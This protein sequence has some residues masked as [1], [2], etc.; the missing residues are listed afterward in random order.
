MNTFAKSILNYFA[1]Y[2]ETRFRFQSKSLYKWTN[3]Q[4]TS[5]FPVFPEFQKKL[6]DTIKAKSLIDLT[7]RKGE[8]T[9]VLDLED[10]KRRLQR[11]LKDK[12]NLSYLD[13]L[14]EELRKENGIVST[15]GNT[16]ESKA[17][18]E[19]ILH[20]A[21]RKFNLNYRTVVRDVLLELQEEKKKELVHF[22]KDSAIPHTS[23]NPSLVEQSIYDA[24]QEQASRARDKGDF[25]SKL[26]GIIKAGTW[27]LEMYD[28]Y[29][30]IRK[31]SAM[32]NQTMGTAYIF[33]HQIFSPKDENLEQ[34]P[35]FLVEITIEE[36]PELVRI[37]SERGVVLINTPAINSFNFDTVLTIPRAARL[38]E[39]PDYL[40]GVE[41]FLQNSY[42]FFNTFLL[43]QAFAPLVATDK[44]KICFRVGFQIVLKEDRKLLDY[45]ELITRIDAGQGGKFIDFVKN[46]VSGN[47]Y[48]TTDEVDREYKK[49]YPPKT[50]ASFLSTIPLTLNR[51]QKRILTALENPKNKIIVIDGPPGT[52]KS[53]TIA[54]MTYW[55]NQN[56]K[57]VVITSHK[58]AAIDVLDRMMTDYF[59]KLHPM[60][61]PSIMRISRETAEG[62]NNFQN[63]LASPVISAAT[64]RA[65][66]FNKNAVE[67]DIE[68]WGKKVA[69][70]TEEYWVNA[71]AYI[72]R[73]KDLLRLEQI[74]HS[75]IQ[76]GMLTEE[77]RPEKIADTGFDIEIIKDIVAHLSNDSDELTLEKLVCLA[78]KK[79]SLDQLIQACNIVN[80]LPITIVEITRLKQVSIEAIDSFENVLHDFKH[81][82]KS[83]SLLFGSDFKLKLYARLTNSKGCKELPEKAKKLKSLEYGDLLNNIAII[84]AKNKDSLVLG[85]LIQG[86]SK[87]KKIEKEREHIDCLVQLRVALE[88]K[89]T[90]IKD[91]YS[92]LKSV[93]GL[94]HKTNSNALNNLIIFADKFESLLAGAKLRSNNLQDL[95]LL[96]DDS[97][98][99]KELLGYITL[100]VALSQ[101]EN[102][103]LPDRQL[104]ESYYESLHKQ[105]ENNN[106]ERFKNLNK[107]SGDIS[108]IET[109]FKT[110][111]RLKKEEAEVLLSNIS[112][113]LSEPDLISQYFPMEENLIDILVIDEAS[114]VS[115][116]ESIS[117][118]LR[119]KQVVVLG[120]E[121]QYGAVGAVNV[122]KEYAAQYFKE[123]LDSYE[124]DYHVAIDEIEKKAL[125]DEVSKEIEEDDQESELFFKP[126]E[127]TKEWLKTFNIRT[128][129]L[130]FAKA[131]RNFSTSLDTHFR[132]FSEII[133]YS[134]EFFYKPS[135]IPL[136]VNRI[137]T[138]PIKDVLRFIKVETKG[139]AGNNINLDEIEVIKGDLSSLITN[140]FKGTVGIITSFRE[141]KYQME[142][143]LRK[144][145]PNFHILE[146]DHKL[147]IWFVGDVQGEER[148][149]VYYS[150]VE[151]K[152]IGN[153][154]LKTIYP[155]PDGTADNIRKLKMQ[156]LNVGFSRAKDT[157]V[158]V[159][160]MPI[161]E[162]S[163]TRLGDALKY[164]QFLF[165]SA[166][167][168]Y[169]V[170][171]KIFGSEA[172]RELY[173]MVINTDFYRKNRDKIKLIAQFPIGKYI[174]ETFHRYIP[175]YR[176]DFLLTISERGKE[177]SLIL[178]YDGI[179]YHT[180]NPDMVTSHNFSQEYLDYDI[181]RQLELENYGYRF[182]RV[183]KFTLLPKEKGQTKID[184]L[185]GLLE[186]KFKN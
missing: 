67:K 88:D 90:E 160:S 60:A 136:I 39:A 92:L 17:L 35:L 124:K 13:S 66:E 165:Q 158:F 41:K 133:D 8:Y 5:D 117:L 178:E 126:E 141:Q 27:N 85:D 29:S 179:E 182:L 175:K 118:L 114:Q 10:F 93:K 23:F 50:A 183:N 31:F 36:R 84:C 139:N 134:N 82:L 172:E 63:S 72:S 146:R 53:Y 74:E 186:Q 11:H 52:G 185:N 89:G 174:K 122:S 34:F 57:S 87:I 61:K 157:M 115:I 137:R 112:C 121:L 145:M 100:F 123:I 58:K 119:A 142:E 51:T 138:K 4:L 77:N 70:Q 131:L 1:T 42:N 86:S 148:D 33:F 64:N 78:E 59:R 180:K 156:R 44:P 81:C 143:I 22:I 55:A 12:F 54:A 152:K 65:N 47:V 18:E 181:E 7:I 161:E 168:N 101:S 116:A 104:V 109:T 26:E 73:T 32:L 132:S 9:V 103:V 129:T 166:K 43:E 184:V 46:Y 140:G 159:H 21:L 25:Y 108:R 30:M 45:S 40:F 164:Y 151:D 71:N 163:D 149:I 107:H 16:G 173:K 14:I 99:H 111:K 147:V 83:D 170:D 28:F 68:E 96:F 153:G 69:I 19:R 3:D 127:G 155:I 171:E 105:L 177:Q 56:N 20:N 169:I 80:S 110:G 91:T 125:V 75:L 94:I 128:S 15:P 37:K 97:G 76:K 2:T 49:K 167:D 6:L 120:D 106:D 150:F 102:I 130:S 154:S 135:Q 48:N 176:V 38:I 113:I 144:E 62:V 95:K 162:Y 98:V 24:F 79:N